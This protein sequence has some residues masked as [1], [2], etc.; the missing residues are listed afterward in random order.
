MGATHSEVISALESGEPRGV[1]TALIAHSV[2]ANTVLDPTGRPVLF[3]AVRT[4]K[5]DISRILV[6]VGHANVNWALDSGVTPLIEAC[7][8]GAP[9][10]IE[11]LITSGAL[12]N[13]S[14]KLGFS[15]LHHAAAL[16]HVDAVRILLAFDA[17]VSANNNF[18]DTPL[19]LAARNGHID[20]VIELDYAK[21]K[22]Y[23]TNDSGDTPLDL[24]IACSKSEV[25]EYLSDACKRR[26]VR[27]MVS[28][29]AWRVQT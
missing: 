10:I 26:P 28:I 22:L 2:D 15:P 16:G 8:V 29:V 6:S 5:V 19:H 12:V 14:D 11:F 27:R 17:T 1:R 13:Q 23:A 24:A 7:K 20:V 21:A 9:P 3:E 25:A 18:R 4:G